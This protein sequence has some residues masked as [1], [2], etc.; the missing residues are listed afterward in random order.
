VK[1]D[2]TLCAVS[3]GSWQDAI[4]LAAELPVDDLLGD[5]YPLERF[6]AAMAL[7]RE[8]PLGPKLFLSPE[9]RT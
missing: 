4:R 5:V 1:N 3:Y 9:V 7:T 6:D 8:R 2:V